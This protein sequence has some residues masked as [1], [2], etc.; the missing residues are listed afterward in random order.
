MATIWITLNYLVYLMPVYASV[1][2]GFVRFI[3][4]FFM[5]W[6]KSFCLNRQIVVLRGFILFDSY[7]L[8]HDN[9]KTTDFFVLF[10]V[11]KNCF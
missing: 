7:L 10:I 2:L 3:C 5:Y 6:W 11:Y 8:P 4:S 9:R 1:H